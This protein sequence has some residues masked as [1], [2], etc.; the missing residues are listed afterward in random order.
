MI[1]AKLRT[2][3]AALIGLAVSVLSCFQA[4]VSLADAV[5]LAVGIVIRFFVTPAV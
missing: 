2:E 4:G 3:P 1:V 5:P